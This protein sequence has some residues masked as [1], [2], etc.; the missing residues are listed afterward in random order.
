MFIAFEA[1][2]GL[3]RPETTAGH[4][5]AL[6]GHMT[7]KDG[8]HAVLGEPLVIAWLEACRFTGCVGQF[9]ELNPLPQITVYWQPRSQKSPWDPP[10]RRS[11]TKQV[12]RRTEQG[13]LTLNQER[14]IER[15]FS[16]VFR[17]IAENSIEL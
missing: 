14:A 10:L 6:S 5:R 2:M 16:Q 13:F 12:V 3:R 7:A 8:V 4:N 9:R 11:Q 1:G 17:A 15:Q